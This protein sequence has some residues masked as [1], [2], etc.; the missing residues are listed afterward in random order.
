MKA[1]AIPGEGPD[2]RGV[3]RR[4]DSSDVQYPPLLADATLLGRALVA[5]HG[6]WGRK[7]YRGAVIAKTLE[8]GVDETRILC[9]RFGL[10]PDEVC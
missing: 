9:A 10:D 2:L 3:V 7:D 6:D 1:P 5:M 4:I 8:I